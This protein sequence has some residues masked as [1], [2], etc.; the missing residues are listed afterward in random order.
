[1]SGVLLCAIAVIGCSD[2][3]GDD[4]ATDATTDATGLDGPCPTVEEPPVVVDRIADAIA[5]VEAELG[6]PQ[7][8]FEINASDLLVNLLVA[9]PDGAEVIPYVWI[10]GETTSASPSPAEGFTFPGSAV[11]VDPTRVTGCVER[12]L[13]SATVQAFVVLGG[14]DDGV[15]YSLI[16]VSDQGGQLVIEVRPDGQV[17]SVD[18]V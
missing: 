10:E 5:A 8:F 11:A 18:P 2:D 14:P 9:S 16:T 3:A 13:P 15:Q 1:V 4:A 6:G 12:D 17:V 7:R